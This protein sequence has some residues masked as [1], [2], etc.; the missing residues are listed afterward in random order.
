TTNLELHTP[1]VFLSRFENLDPLWKEKF[2]KLQKTITIRF[3]DRLQLKKILSLVGF[4]ETYIYVSLLIKQVTTDNNKKSDSA[5]EKKKEK[6]I[7][8]NCSKVFE[9]FL[10]VLKREGADKA[11]PYILAKVITHDYPMGNNF[12]MKIKDGVYVITRNDLA[13]SSYVSKTSEKLSNVYDIDG[14]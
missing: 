3:C 7:E 9:S 8:P 11:N 2:E 5:E 10:D 12:V 14:K 1:V 4:V 13:Q 6:Q